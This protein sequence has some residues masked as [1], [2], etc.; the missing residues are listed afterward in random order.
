M[1]E[2]TCG[3]W[4]MKE[5]PSPSYAKAIRS[6]ESFGRILE[7]GELHNSPG[8]SFSRMRVLGSYAVVLLTGGEG[9]YQLRGRPTIRCRPG[10]L[11]LVF[12]EIAHAYGPLP[13]G[14]WNEVYVVF[15]G[16]IFDLWRRAGFLNPEEPIW[17]GL[18]VRSLRGELRKFSGGSWRLGPAKRLEWICRLQEILAM[19][20]SRRSAPSDGGARADWP[21]WLEDAVAEI[22]ANPSIS[23]EALARKAGMTYETFRKKFRACTGSSPMVFCGRAAMD[24]ARKWIYEERL[25]NKEIAERLGF[26]DEFHFSKRFRQITGVTTRAFRNSLPGSRK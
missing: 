10:D 16:R 5:H 14:E 22:Q 6:E 2:K 23:P 1:R 26:C 3:I 19:A 18:P 17:Q 8:V 9:V 7:A 11:L 21:S 12:P 25:T 15:E 20:F 4:E 13:G 24:F